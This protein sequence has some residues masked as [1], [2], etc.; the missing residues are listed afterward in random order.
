MVKLNVTPA[1][2]SYLVYRDGG[3][4]LIAPKPVYP[5]P[6]SPMFSRAYKFHAQELTYF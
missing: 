3:H 4:H 6:F 2:A 1:I 5:P